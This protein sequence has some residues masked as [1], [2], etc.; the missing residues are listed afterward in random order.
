MLS[1]YLLLAFVV[2]AHAGQQTLIW[3]GFSHDWTYNHRCN[4]IGDY[5]LNG[6]QALQSV[7]TSATGIGADRTDFRSLFVAV[8]SPQLRSR[9]GHT[10][11]EIRSEEGTLVTGTKEFRFP[12]VA[13]EKEDKADQFV[14]L[15]NGFD[16]KSNADADKLQYLKLYASEVEMND[17]EIWFQI[18]YEIILSCESLECKMFDRRVNY[19]LDVHFIVLG[20]NSDSASVTKAKFSDEN[21]WNKKKELTI[22]ENKACLLG[23]ACET[24]S[25]AFLGIQSFSI[26]LD[27]SE[28]L[29]EWAMNVRPESYTASD[30]EL[31][32]VLNH[33]FKSWKK[34][35]QS[36]SAWECKKFCV[37]G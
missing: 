22:N 26:N 35:M 2:N 32:F 37:T 34:G 8:D 25:Q 1:I 14:A 10:V 33:G 30:G 4:R 21:K 3:N 16:L 28:W 24:F 31:S 27:R 23:V 19:D 15:L 17:S 20:M 29:L 11:F 18:H 36:E 7:H 12:R 9:S 13:F 6:E 5:V